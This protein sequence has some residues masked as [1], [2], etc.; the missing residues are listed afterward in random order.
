VVTRDPPNMGLDAVEKRKIQALP[1]IEIIQKAKQKYTL[2]LRTAFKYV[3]ICYLNCTASDT[4]LITL[5][6]NLNITYFPYVKVFFLE[7]AIHSS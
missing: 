5:R 2:F 3:K 7:E 1:G 4:V 6:Y